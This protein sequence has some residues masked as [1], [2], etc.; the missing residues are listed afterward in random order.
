MIGILCSSV[1]AI[2]LSILK[3]SN[4]A[5]NCSNIINQESISDINPH[6]DGKIET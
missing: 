2:G 1:F 5:V 6:G 3:C 4:R